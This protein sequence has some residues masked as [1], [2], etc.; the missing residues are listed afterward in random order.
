MAG[1][2]LWRQAFDAVDRR[3]A[4]PVEGTARSDA[5]GD[6]LALALRLERRVQRGIER[7]SRRLLHLANLPTATDVRRLS[8]QVSALRRE[9]RELEQRRP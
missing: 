4:G 3:I 1:K 7:R 2:P 5:F 6:A 8:E 9:V